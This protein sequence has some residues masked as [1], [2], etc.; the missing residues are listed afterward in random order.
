MMLLLSSVS[1]HEP[2]VL[3]VTII[4]RDADLCGWLRLLKSLWGLG[5]SEI[6]LLAKYY[7]ASIIFVCFGFWILGVLSRGSGK[8][9]NRDQEEKQLDP[10]PPRLFF[11]L[12]RLL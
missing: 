7:Y 1:C 9:V 8:V 10:R 2:F 4:G 3:Q 11:Y 6:V 12:V 5:A